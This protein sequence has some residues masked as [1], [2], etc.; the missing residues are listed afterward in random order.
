VPAH[1][2]A[3]STGSS[4]KRRRQLRPIAGKAA[5]SHA[6]DSRSNAH[7]TSRRAALHTRR[8]A[9]GAHDTESD[10][11][12]N[13]FECVA[14][15]D[16]AHKTTCARPYDILPEY[17]DSCTRSPVPHYETRSPVP[18]YETR[19]PVPHY[20]TRSPVPHYESDERAGSRPQRQ[21]LPSLL[22]RRVC[23]TSR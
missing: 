8:C 14:V 6:A 2:P 19:S 10:R 17:G 18:H 1:G 21:S 4:S 23:D 20:E 15:A 16:V 7:P 9:P 22:S 12:P 11:V 3:Q 5:H 13:L